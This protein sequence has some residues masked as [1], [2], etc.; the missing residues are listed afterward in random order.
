MCW[1][2]CFKSFCKADLPWKTPLRH[3]FL[4][5]QL[6]YPR[7]IGWSV[8]VHTDSTS[9]VED[10]LLKGQPQSIHQRTD[11]EHQ[12]SARHK[13]GNGNIKMNTTFWAHV[14]CQGYLQRPHKAVVA[15]GL[16]FL[17]SLYFFFSLFF[18]FFSSS[19]L[20]L[21]LLALTFFRPPCCPHHRPAS[22]TQWLWQALLKLLTALKLEMTTRMSVQDSN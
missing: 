12:Q 13:A 16:V 7:T 15:C 22:A 1:Y 6:S 10:L 21:T 2:S 20:P 8:R 9:P 17:F 18:S 14:L 11:P 19:C 4:N 3:H 5:I